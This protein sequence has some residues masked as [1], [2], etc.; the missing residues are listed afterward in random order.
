M[1]KLLLILSSCTLLASCQKSSNLT[2]APSPAK[3]THTAP[4][5]QSR[6]L[7]APLTFC[8]SSVQTSSDS[9]EIYVNKNGGDP[10]AYQGS[11]SISYDL[12]TPS[13]T[14]HI[15]WLGISSWPYD[16]GSTGLG[17]GVSNIV[18]RQA[19]PGVDK[20]GNPTIIYTTYIVSHC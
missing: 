6:V 15:G 11:F 4:A 3:T 19:L 1:K 12:T 7:Y 17:A 20:N 8:Y 14:T 13:G 2:P 18:V 16:L 5:A 10:F 9:W